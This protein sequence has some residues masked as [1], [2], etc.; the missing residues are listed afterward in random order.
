VA[1]IDFLGAMHTGTP[2]NYLQRVVESDKAA[3]AAVARRF[4]EQYFD[5]D[6][7]YGYGGY[8]YDGRWQAVAQRLAA[9]Y[10][11]LPGARI[12][13]I[14][15]G[16]AFLLH[17]LLDVV[18]GA[19]VSGLDISRYAIANAMPSVR[20][21]LVVGTADALPYPD[22]SFDL[23]LAINTLHNLRAAALESALREMQRV[24]R[25]AKYLVVDAFRSERE[26]VN[27]LYWQLTCQ[28]FYMPED[29]EWWF[30]HTGY[31]GDY[32]F[33]VFE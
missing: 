6:R 10:G 14:G 5:G 26:K 4:D 25:G 22:G 2:R 3:C 29:W 19:R 9:H 7:Q 24:G 33:V 30:G 32:S 11:L 28:C 12:L 23:V 31:S 21:R 27:L 8:R 17:D 1:Y 20:P 18:P 16:K 15:C 13:D